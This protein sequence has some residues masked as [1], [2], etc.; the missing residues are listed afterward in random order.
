MKNEHKT[1]KKGKVLWAAVIV[2]SVLTIILG[3]LVFLNWDYISFKVFLTDRYLKTDILDSIYEEYVGLDADGHYYKYF[4]NLSIAAVTKLIRDSGK[5]N[6]TYQY[7]P[8]QFEDYTSNREEKAEKS[9]VE[10]LTPDT[11]Y[12]LLTNFTPASLKFFQDSVEEIGGY[13]NLVLDLRGNGGGDLDV[14]FE[15]ADYFVEK[16]SVLVIEKRRHKSTNIDAV[17]NKSLYFEN[18]VILQDKNTAS[19]SEQLITALDANIAG[20]TKVGT[21][22]RG[23]YVGQTRISLLR[24]FYVKATTLEW[25]SPDG[26]AQDPNGIPP[27]Y[28]Y[29]GEDIISYVLDEIL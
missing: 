22:T 10:Q 14:I 2:L 6:Y 18:M 29:E 4:D 9:Y 15:I 28:G 21:R 23:K 8:E 11:V 12:M 17:K 27:D 16:G 20:L 19:A 1:G 13:E 26:R 3:T 7:N 24:N 5:D 25:V